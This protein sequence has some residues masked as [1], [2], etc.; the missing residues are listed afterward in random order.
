M[1]QGIDF[2][3]SGWCQVKLI[4]CNILVSESVNLVGWIGAPE[5]G[6]GNELKGQCAEA[7]S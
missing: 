5:F 2:P 7:F 6:L 1:S 3:R 4:I